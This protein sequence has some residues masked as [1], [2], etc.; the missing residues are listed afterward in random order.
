MG[1]LG[2]QSQ[3]ITTSLLQDMAAVAARNTRMRELLAKHGYTIPAAS[4]A[5]GLATKDDVKSAATVKTT[6]EE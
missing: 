4:E 3:Q 6:E 1:I 5:S 2:A